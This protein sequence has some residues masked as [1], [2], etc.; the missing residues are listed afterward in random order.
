LRNE[1]ENK[2]FIP[3]FGEF[4]EVFKYIRFAIWKKLS[5]GEKGKFLVFIEEMSVMLFLAYTFSK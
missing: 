2:I 4:Y 3:S 5:L 1:V